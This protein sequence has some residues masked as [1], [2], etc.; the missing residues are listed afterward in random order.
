MPMASGGYGMLISERFGRDAFFD[1]ATKNFLGSDVPSNAGLKPLRFE[2]SQDIS[3]QLVEWPLDHCIKVPVLLSSRRSG[4]A[5]EER[6]A[7]KA[8]HAVR[9][10]TQGRPRTAGSRSSPTRTGRSPT[11]PSRRR[12]KNF[13]RSA[14]RPDWWRKL[15]PQASSAAWKKIDAVIAGN[16]PWC[17]GM[18]LLGLEAPAD[19][20]VKASR[21]RWQHPPVKGFA[22]GRTI[23]S[24]CGA[25]LAVGQDR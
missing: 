9:G 6:T 13:M 16:D 15:E 19:E 24:G 23:F 25:G 8:A 2:F 21:R 14:S 12:W 1:A 22:V 5:E 3:S 17:R 4:G 7:G 20:L 11:T 18:V 10:G